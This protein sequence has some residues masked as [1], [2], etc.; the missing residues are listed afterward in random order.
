MTLTH[1]IQLDLLAFLKSSQFDFIK[2]GQSKEWILANF[3]D[4][5]DFGEQMLN[6]KWPIWTYDRL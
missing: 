3:P 2:L 4:P 6:P 5:D 1:P